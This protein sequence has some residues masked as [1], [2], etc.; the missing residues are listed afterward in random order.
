MLCGRIDG[1]T[2]FEYP[3]ELAAGES[4][5]VSVSPAEIPGLHLENPRLWWPNGYGDQAMYDLDLRVKCGGAE[6]DVRRV[7]FGVREFSYELT[8]RYAPGRRDSF[9]V[10]AH[11]RR[12]RW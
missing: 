5:T 3:V 4:R 11:E 2:E 7:R 10:S 8:G 12:T 1:V 9:R 6:S